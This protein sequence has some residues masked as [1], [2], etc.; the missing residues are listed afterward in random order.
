MVAAEFVTEDSAPNTAAAASV[1][2]SSLDEREL[3]IRW[4]TFDQAIPIIP[5]LVVTE[6]QICELLDV[7]RRAV[8]RL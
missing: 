6:A 3:L 4:G 1:M 5:P 2:R 8:A 7:F